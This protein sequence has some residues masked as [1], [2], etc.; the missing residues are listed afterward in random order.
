[1]YITQELT[2]VQNDCVV[3]KSVPKTTFLWCAIR[4]PLLM[5]SKGELEIS[6]LPCGMGE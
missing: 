2:Q 4:W 1:M 5:I 6:K 3:K